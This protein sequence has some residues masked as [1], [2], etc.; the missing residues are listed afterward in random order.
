MIKKEISKKSKPRSGANVI[1]IINNIEEALEAK[2]KASLSYPMD[3]SPDISNSVFAMGFIGGKD[4][5]TKINYICKIAA[6]KFCCFVTPI[7]MDVV[8]CGG[9]DI[10]DIFKDDFK[11]DSDRT[12]PTFNMDTG[13]VEHV[14]P[15]L[16]VVNKKK[17]SKQPDMVDVK[18]TVDPEAIEKLDMLM[19]EFTILD[20]MEPSLEFCNDDNLTVNIVNTK[21]I[22]TSNIYHH[23]REMG[24]QTDKM[25]ELA[26]VHKVR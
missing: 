23:V 1:F 7:K 11:K 26:I 16:N 18:F 10:W 20:W 19:G 6:S 15:L 9:E 2:S 12:I 22:L 13:K 3:L 17:P 4:I 21:Q 5:D 14:S 8:D 25:P 24:Y